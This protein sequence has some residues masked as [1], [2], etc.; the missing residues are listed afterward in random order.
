MEEKD[1]LEMQASKEGVPSFVEEL[2]EFDDHKAS[3]KRRKQ[4]RG[5]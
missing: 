2:N 3:E 1:D 4:K 5:Y